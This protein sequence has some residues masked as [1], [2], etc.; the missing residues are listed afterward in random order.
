MGTAH[1]RRRPGAGTSVAQV[2]RMTFGANI[3]PPKSGYFILSLKPDKIKVVNAEAGVMRLLTTVI[4]R[5]VD[6]VKEGWDRHLTYCFRLHVEACHQMIQL[7][8]DTLMSLYQSGWEPMTPL[9]MGS[10]TKTK[11]IVTNS[12]IDICFRNKEGGINTPTMGSTYSIRRDSSMTIQEENSCLCLQTYKD[13]YLICHNVSNTCLYEL[14]TS[15]Q[16]S[17]TPGIA[18]VSVGVASVIQV[19]GKLWY[20]TKLFQ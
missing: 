13:S 3:P 4:K 9:E 1:S 6:I 12:R 17:W 15:V 7:V 11:D 2:A 8:A 18:G 16:D 10:K 5:H 19:S 14:V 20:N